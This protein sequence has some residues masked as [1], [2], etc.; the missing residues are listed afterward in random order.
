MTLS[1]LASRKDSHFKH[2]IAVTAVT[3][4]QLTRFADLGGK[5]T[6][7]CRGDLS[8]SLFIYVEEAKGLSVL[9]HIILISSYNSLLSGISSFM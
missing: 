8:A 2:S 7:S 3:A 4:G 9:Q 5:Y 1:V 6:G